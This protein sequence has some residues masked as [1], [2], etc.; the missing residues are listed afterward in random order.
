[1]PEL[2]EV[3]VTRCALEPHVV[4]KTVQDIIIRQPRLR[5]PIPKELP[6]RMLG[7][8]IVSITR[9]GK[10][11]LWQVPGGAAIM[12]L[13]MTGCL[14][15]LT[16]DSPPQKHDHVDIIFTDG[17]RIRYTD[18][19]RFGAM[20][21]A[22]DPV[23]SHRLLHAM[24]VEPLG[25]DFSAKYLLARAAKR[26]IPTKQL[27]M[28]NHVVVGVGNIYA[29]E[30]LFL[31]R[32]APTL[33]ANKLSLG[34]CQALYKHTRAVL[35]AAIKQGGTTFRDFKRPEGKPGYFKQQL[36]VYGRAGQPCQCCGTELS[37]MKIG[38]RSTFYC[39]SCQAIA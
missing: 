26:R 2:P 6:E 13:G 9:R 19:R 15:V 27:L 3:E 1:M 21:W 32:I 14:R 39:S 4:G 5:W 30:A 38:G 10:Y 29:C 33:P 31:A 24:G 22:D 7:Q 37:T 35:R 8:T 12:H 23:L 25:D 20:L 36:A 11:L 17:G 34:Q 16:K 28:D 18:P